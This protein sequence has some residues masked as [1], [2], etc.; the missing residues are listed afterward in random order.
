MAQGYWRCP[1]STRTQ[2]LS[3]AQHSGSKDPALV[4]LRHKL[5]LRLRSDPWPR[6]SM[7]CRAAKK[8]KQN[9]RVPGVVLQLVNPTSIQEDAG[10]IPGLAQR[11]KDPAWPW[12][13][14]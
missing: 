10:S 9:K 8:R 3:L 7:C 6:S 5:R 2:V 4:Q 14:V 13:V 11:V 12:A 1:C